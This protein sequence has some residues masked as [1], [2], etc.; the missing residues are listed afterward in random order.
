MSHPD[1]LKFRILVAFFLVTVSVITSLVILSELVLSYP[2]ILLPLFVSDPTPDG[3]EASLEDLEWHTRAQASALAFGAFVFVW[4]KLLIAFVHLMIKLRYFISGSRRCTTDTDTCSVGSQ[5]C[6]FMGGKECHSNVRKRCTGSRPYVVF[7]LAVIII[8]D[9]IYNRCRETTTSGACSF[10]GLD[11]FTLP[12]I[13]IPGSSIIP[14]ASSYLS[15]AMPV[16][17]S[18]WW[19]IQTLLPGAFTRLFSMA[20]RSL[21]ICAGEVSVLFLALYAM[22]VWHRDRSMMDLESLDGASSFSQGPSNLSEGSGG[23]L[24]LGSDSEVVPNAN[25][26]ELVPL[27]VEQEMKCRDSDLG[28][29]ARQ[30][31]LYRRGEEDDAVSGLIRCTEDVVRSH[32]DEKKDLVLD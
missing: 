16:V 27:G 14:S 20:S 2:G 21:P 4:Y 29:F 18:L 9:S 31:R 19:S 5:D 7:L 8:N 26:P 3:I 12:T 25:V 13:P 28:F 1:R 32:D 10:V 11:S 30:W 6:P 23:G 22:G 17:T 15:T 24:K